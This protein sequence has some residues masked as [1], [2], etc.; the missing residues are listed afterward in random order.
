M[1][2]LR[3]RLLM[4]AIVLGS[5]AAA[6]AAAAGP[7]FQ[8]SGTMAAGK[9]LSIYGISGVVTVSRAAGREASVTAEKSGKSKH[10]DEV[11][12]E[13]SPGPDGIT[14]CVLYPGRHDK[15]MTCQAGK[16]LKGDADDVDADVD[17]T[18]KVPDGVDLEVD[19]VNGNIEALDLRSDV[20]AATVNGSIRASTS[21]LAEASSVN[22]S[23]TVSMGR[24]TWDR[25]LKFATVNGSV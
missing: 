22:G 17:F 23:I 7:D 1:K 15:M 24:G 4:A 25:P 11:R 8:W 2:S 21:G 10:F 19:Q 9:K 12:V 14:I 20:N 3:T 13:V 6:S 18:V 16:G 5:S